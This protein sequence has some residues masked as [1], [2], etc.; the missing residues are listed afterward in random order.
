MRSEERSGII[1]IALILLWGT[2]I[3]EPF[4]YFTELI[5]GGADKLL[6]KT[7][8]TEC[9]KIEGIIMSVFFGVNAIILI[10][11][12]SLKRGIFIGVFL[13]CLAFTAFL[14]T[15]LVEGRIRTGALIVFCVFSI[16]F[17]LASIFKIESFFIWITDAFLLSF[18]VFL[19]FSWILDHIAQMSERASKILFVCRKSTTD[20]ALPFKGFLTAPALVWGVF[21]FILSVLP[22][23]YFIP[24]R[25]KG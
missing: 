8:I 22:V 1:A 6:L 14:T 19:L 12:S 21:I 5:F 17:I 10:K 15:C 9:G 3:T 7:G 2:L 18:P 24:G 11:L 4:R 16:A 25:R 23:I 20:L 13:F